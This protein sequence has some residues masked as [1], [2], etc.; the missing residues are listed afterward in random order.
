M[1]RCLLCSQIT[2][3]ASALFI[4][5]VLARR[6][7]SIVGDSAVALLLGLFAGIFFFY[8]VSDMQTDYGVASAAKFGLRNHVCRWK[9]GTD[10]SDGMCLQTDMRQTE[11][12]SKATSLLCL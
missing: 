5:Q 12:N 2:L 7:V 10:R 8:L 11:V 9:K 3:L 4:G 6:K 1:L